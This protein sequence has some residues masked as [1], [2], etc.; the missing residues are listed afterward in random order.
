MARIAIAAA[1]IAMIAHTMGYAGFLSDPLTWALL[2]I[3]MLYLG[4]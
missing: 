3:T 1:F 4:R 2:A